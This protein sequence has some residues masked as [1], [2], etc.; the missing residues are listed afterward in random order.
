VR[1]RYLRP[2][3]IG[4]ALPWES[5]SVEAKSPHITELKNPLNFESHVPSPPITREEGWMLSDILLFHKC[6]VLNC[7][8][9]TIYAIVRLIMA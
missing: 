6:S 1:I 7:Q 8:R 3:T 2:F 4:S 9:L 5:V